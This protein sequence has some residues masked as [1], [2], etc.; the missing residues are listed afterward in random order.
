LIYLINFIA[1][2]VVFLVGTGV[3]LARRNFTL[4]DV[5]W[6]GSIGL[7]ALICYIFFNNFT[8]FNTIS[9]L[10]ALFWCLRLVVFL[11]I[12]R[13]RAGINDRR[14]QGL[15]LQGK[16]KF[17]VTN[18]A[19][20]LITSYLFAF[21]F[22]FVFDNNVF[23]V[24]RIIG[25]VISFTSIFLEWYCD[26]G[27]HRFK[28]SK[29]TGVYQ[30]GLWKYSRHPNLFFEVCIWMGFAIQAMSSFIGLVGL[31]SP[32]AAFMTTYFL[33]IPVTERTSLKKR[34]QNYASYVAT[35][36]KLVIWKKRKLH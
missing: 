27:L 23:I 6:T 33:T 2:F 15:E 11:Y 8:L 17:V 32:L 16:A 25:Y 30:G 12:T 24:P 3:C 35:T 19:L 36:S 20:Q 29:G 10:I 5:V 4:I 26:W 14:Y 1:V 22:Y 7:Q 28:L 34:K 31:I 18:F 9:L 21:C 13:V